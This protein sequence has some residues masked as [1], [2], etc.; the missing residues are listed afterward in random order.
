M[1]SRSGRYSSTILLRRSEWRIRKNSFVRNDVIIK[2]NQQVTIIAMQKDGILVPFTTSKGHNIA[3]MRYGILSVS[4]MF[5]SEHFD[6]K[7]ETWKIRLAGVFIMYAATV[8]LI[9]LLKIICTFVFNA[10]KLKFIGVVCRFEIAH[11]KDGFNARNFY[12]R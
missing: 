8:C 6:L 5:D 4:Q 3:L 11:L 10:C 7:L 12:D 2:I 9:R 1:E